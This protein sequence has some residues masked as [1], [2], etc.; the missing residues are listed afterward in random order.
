MHSKLVGGNNFGESIY[1]SND[2]R[3]SLHDL[4]SM[5]VLVNAYVPVYI[6]Y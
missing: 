5:R 3:N 1:L 4:V 2:I 6:C